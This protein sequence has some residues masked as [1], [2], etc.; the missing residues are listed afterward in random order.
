MYG[1][2]CGSRR[3]PPITS[4]E[5]PLFVYFHLDATTQ[6]GSFK[7]IHGEVPS[8]FATSNTICTSNIRVNER[9]MIDAIFFKRLLVVTL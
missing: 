4:N 5:R 8:K 1:T 2:F 7:A 6:G 9:Q 3:L